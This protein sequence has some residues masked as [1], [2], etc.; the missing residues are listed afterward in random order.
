MPATKRLIF[1]PPCATCGATAVY[2]AIDFWELAQG[3]YC[4]AHIVDMLARLDR[5][6]AEYLAREREERRE[7][8][9]P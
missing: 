5:E 9:S 1:Q 4:A 2:E 3:T 8:P 7:N 6:E